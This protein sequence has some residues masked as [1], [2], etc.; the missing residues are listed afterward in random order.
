MPIP[1]DPNTHAFRCLVEASLIQGA[2]KASKP[3]PLSKNR[4]G[5]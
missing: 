3:K 2:K 1:G 4:G 5:V